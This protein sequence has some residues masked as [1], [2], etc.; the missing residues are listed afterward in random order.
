MVNL[1]I[2]SWLVFIIFFLRN[3][4]GYGDPI[5]T[6]DHPPSA[7]TIQ[8]AD[9]NDV[10]SS[11]VSVEIYVEALCIDSKNY[12]REQVLPAYERLGT[13]IVNFSIVSFGNA[14]FASD[15]TSITCQHG[16][17]ECDANAYQ[18]CASFVYDDNVT[19]YLPFLACLFETLPMGHRDDLFDVSV[20]ASC[21][22]SLHWPSLRKCHD[23]P[24][25][26]TKLQQ[27]AA[28]AT[29][30][31]HTYVPWVVIDGIHVDET[32][33][34]LVDMICDAYKGTTSLCPD[35]SSAV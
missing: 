16:A 23:S 22:G 7:K 33:G 26:V 19:R 2:L 20:F 34:N 31:E 12:M 6:S 10:Q 3:A 28:S 29:P 32:S 11:K 5:A 35:V 30:A 14:E 27:Q 4:D 24:G 8:K 18:Q 1:M 21:S 17:A 15:H 25:L 13:S 9:T